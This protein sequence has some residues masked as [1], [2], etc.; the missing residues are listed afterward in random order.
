MTLNE[1]K[2]P[3]PSTL[4]PPSL[5]R[6]GAWSKAAVSGANTRSRSAGSKATD[7]AASRLAADY[8]LEYRNTKL[9]VNEAKA[10]NEDLT[11]GVGRSEKLCSR[12]WRCGSHFRQT[13]TASIA[14]TCRLAREGEIATYP[15]PEELWNQTFT[16]PDSWRDR[17][18]AVPFQDKGGSHQSRYYQDIA[19]ERVMEAIAANKP[20]IPSHARDRD[21]QDVYCISDCL[22]ALF[23]CT[24]WNL[25]RE[26]SRRPRILFLADRNILADQAYNAF[27]SFPED[28]MVRIAPDDIRKKGK[29]A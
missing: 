5:R 28:A 20:R 2:K 27:S 25:S 4:T 8:V 16:K 11:E 6:A 17:F 13:G 26:P 23:P 1:S 15:T 9:A 22:E 3:E 19:V 14:S 10:W 24:R 21:G 7:G 12:S 18:A 29:G